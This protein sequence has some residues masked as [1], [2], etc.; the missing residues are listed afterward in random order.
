LEAV[1]STNPRLVDTQELET[2]L[3]EQMIARLKSS[4]GGNPSNKEGEMLAE[5]QGARAKN[6]EVRKRIIARAILV[7]EERLENEKAKLA[8]INAKKW[9]QVVN[10]EKPADKPAA[11][12]SE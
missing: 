5:L 7:A 12:G 11:E 2:L 4:F 1:N 8:D 6:N 10:P 3:G 9:Q